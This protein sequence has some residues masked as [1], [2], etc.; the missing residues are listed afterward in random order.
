MFGPIISFFKRVQQQR[1]SRK[2]GIIANKCARLALKKYKVSLIDLYNIAGPN[3]RK[4]ILLKIGAGN[5][6]STKHY[7]NF[8]SRAL[9]AYPNPTY[10]ERLQYI[11]LHELRVEFVDWCKNYFL[12][13]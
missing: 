4:F 3:K 11:D 7:K 2:T 5:I 1:I 12:R 6:W 13:Q 10:S 9:D 8:L